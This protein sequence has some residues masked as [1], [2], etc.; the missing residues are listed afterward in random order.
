MKKEKF[1]WWVKRVKKCAELYDT[2][3]IDHF[4][5][6]DTYWAIPYGEKTAINGKW[7]IGPRMDFFSAISHGL[8]AVDIIAEDLG[9]V[10][11][12]VGELLRATGYP[13]MKVLQFGFNPGN[14][15]S[16]H[17][18]HHYPL[19]SVAYTGTHD[20][21]TLKG[22]LKNE[23][24]E[25]RRMFKNY[26]KPALFEGLNFA[27]FRSLYQ[28]SARLVVLP[29]QDVLGLDDKARMNIPSTLGG[30]WIWRMKQG[31]N[32]AGMADKMKGLVK[33]YF[34]C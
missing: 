23:K 22:W 31:K 2:I 18:P 17:L 16:D 11:D 5:A 7:E 28:S 4:R 1:L 14:N 9:E 13:G 15:D 25:T 12:S 32:T 26:L 30:N 8:G 10:F 34:R 27:A 33:T 21:S 19:N 3:R 24:S 6:F 29:M 20:N